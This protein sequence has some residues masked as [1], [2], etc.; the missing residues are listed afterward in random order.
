MF[1]AS[2]RRPPTQARA[3]AL[4]AASGLAHSSLLADAER[5]P[6]SA[7]QP[8][9]AGHR[10]SSLGQTIYRPA[11]MLRR[12][13]GGIGASRAMSARCRAPVYVSRAKRECRPRELGPTQAGERFPSAAGIS[14]QGPLPP[15]DVCGFGSPP[16]GPRK[17]GPAW[18]QATCIQRMVAITANQ[19]TRRERRW[20]WPSEG[21][22]SQSGAHRSSIVSSPLLIGG[23]SFGGRSPQGLAS[24]VT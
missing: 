6:P 14:G 18:L 15:A 3:V 5:L 10:S 9:D 4:G 17:S 19:K 12:S 8:P 22:I 11:T 23:R 1:R 24:A 21:S 13:W 7:L 2:R 16:M 20:P